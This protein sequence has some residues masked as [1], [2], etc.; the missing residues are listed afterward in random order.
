M[1]SQ[2]LDNGFHC[3][4]SLGLT[5]FLESGQKRPPLFMFLFAS[6][7]FLVISLTDLRQYLVEAHQQVIASDVF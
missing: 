2:A 4:P 6:L 3:W 5:D 1:G 7:G